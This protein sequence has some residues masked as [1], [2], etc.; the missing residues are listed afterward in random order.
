MGARGERKLGRGGV[1]STPGPL[2]LTTV[3]GSC[4]RERKEGN[5]KYRDVAWMRGEGRGRGGWGL[6]YHSVIFYGVVLLGGKK[7][8]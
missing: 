4:K 6:I 2:T 3:P 5:S 1:A 8:Q 7:A